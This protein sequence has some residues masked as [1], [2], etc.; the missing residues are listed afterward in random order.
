MLPR[1]L[2]VLSRLACLVVILSFVLFAVNQTSKA[3]THQQNELN[4]TTQPSSSRP[5]E[6]AV[7]KAIDEAAAKI[8]SPFSKLT[9]GSKNEW[10]VRGG[11]AAL[12]LL[13]YGFGVGF[14]ARMVALRV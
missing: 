14:L 3:S 9:S 2:Q 10:V 6:S 12:A 8:T 7:H 13:I 4:G 1:L 11:D 5:K